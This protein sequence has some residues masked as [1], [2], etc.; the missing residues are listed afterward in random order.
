MEPTSL[1]E[2]FILEAPDYPTK[3]QLL[4]QLLE[5]NATLSRLQLDDALAQLHFENKIMLDDHGHIIYVGV[6]NPKLQKLLDES[7]PLR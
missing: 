5:A 6:N 1:V 3:P 7:V 2:K 4:K